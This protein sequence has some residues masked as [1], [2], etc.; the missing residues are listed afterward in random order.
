[1]ALDL[2]LIVTRVLPLAWAQANAAS[3]IRA[4][5]FRELISSDTCTSSGVPTASARPCPVYCPSVFS[6]KMT[7][8]MVVLP[9]SA[10][11]SAL[12]GESRGW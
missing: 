7:K 10:R 6:R 1:M 3:M 12:S 2:S 4:T 5:P 8:S 9:P 11:R